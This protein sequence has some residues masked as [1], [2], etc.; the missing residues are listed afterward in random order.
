MNRP[1]AFISAMFGEEEYR[2]KN[3]KRRST[4]GNTDDLSINLVLN[5]DSRNGGNLC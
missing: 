2:I 5:L 3:I 4:C 1:D